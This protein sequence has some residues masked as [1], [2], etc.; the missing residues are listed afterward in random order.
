MSFEDL[1]ALSILLEGSAETTLAR[2][3]LFS[4]I[5]RAIPPTDFTLTIQLDG[6]FL[7]SQGETQYVFSPNLADGIADYHALVA[8]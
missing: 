6:T 4:K 8:A 5:L 7:A 3:P 2:W 1:Y